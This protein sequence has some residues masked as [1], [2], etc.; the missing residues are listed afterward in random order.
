MSDDRDP[1]CPICRRSIWRYAIGDAL[2]L[3]EPY[4]GDAIERAVA[5]IRYL[6]EREQVANEVP[7]L[8]ATL[9]E[10]RHVVAALRAELAAKDKR[11]EE[12]EAQVAGKSRLIAAQ[13][14]LGEARIEEICR[15]AV[16]VK[17]A[18]RALVVIQPCPHETPGRGGYAHDMRLQSEAIALINAALDGKDGDA[19]GR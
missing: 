16:A 8:S 10:A 12:L 17:A 3:E 2:G 7:G 6:R 4:M 15:L 11:I 18:H 14:G 9:D 1:P 13:R 19:N 5:S